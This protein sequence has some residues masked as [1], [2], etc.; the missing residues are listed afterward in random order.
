MILPHSQAQED[1]SEHC[2]TGSCLNK[3]IDWK[4]DQLISGFSL[5]AECVEP[6]FTY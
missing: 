3:A 2:T 4:Q 1:A 6:F 5:L